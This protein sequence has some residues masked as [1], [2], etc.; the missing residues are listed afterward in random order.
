MVERLC[1]EN[2]LTEEP[3]MPGPS[4]GGDTPMSPDVPK[5]TTPAEAALYQDAYNNYSAANKILNDALKNHQ[6][7]I[8]PDTGVI[9]FNNAKLT[10]DFN[11]P[12]SKYNSD[13]QQLEAI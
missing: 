4:F 10:D 11:T 9:D 2:S 7:K 13:L 6:A 5:N 3:I 8:D 1:A 12:V